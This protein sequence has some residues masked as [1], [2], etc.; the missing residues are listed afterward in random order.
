M[1]KQFLL[2]LFTSLF[3][4][5]CENPTSDN[6]S[7]DSTI[8]LG[9]D[10]EL[11]ISDWSTETHSNDVD[12][13]YGI[14][15]EENS[16][17]RIDIT[18]SES[19]W[20]AMQTDLDENLTGSVADIDF[21]P[22]WVPSTLSFEGK[23]WY[24][25]GVRY[26]G[27]STLLNASR[28]NGDKYPFKLDFDEFEDE[29]P[30]IDNQR[31]YGFKQLNLSNNDSD[32]SFMREKIAADL[33]REFGVAAPRVAFYA[34]YLDRGNGSNFIG[35]YSLIE[36]VDDSVP[37]SQFPDND[38]NLYKP[39]GDAASFALGTYDESEFDLKTN[40]D[41]ANFSDVKAF[42]D[43]LNS[44]LRTS[45]ESQ[46]KSDL[47]AIFNVDTYLKYLAANNVIQNW[48]TYGIMT[49]NYFL[50]NDEGK[51]TWIP[52]DNNEAFQDG[53]QGG[54]LSL[55]MNEVGSDWPIIRY[56]MDVD[57]YETI[58]ISYVKEFS[59][60][61]FETSKMNTLLSSYESL[62]SEYASQESS[63][64]S[65]SVSSLKSYISQRNAVAGSF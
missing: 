42:F 24:K 49:H 10:T 20:S 6:T 15:F 64:F 27:N 29:F 2:L 63:G 46:W 36:E 54:A 65:N 61:A 5:F 59:E 33:F 38:G 40:E 31:F 7:T 53:K 28:S 47:E 45:N 39:D 16:I 35:I 4:T 52:W 30:Q 57:D 13:N 19:N 44:D 14:V 60:G 62:L 11:E 17:K 21:T 1:N 25:V 18:I 48:D 12:P 3:L 22:V 26:K 8:D 55:G 56:I 34:V 23:D 32:G 50:Y 43:L 9:K 37:D 51:L 58:Y 41:E